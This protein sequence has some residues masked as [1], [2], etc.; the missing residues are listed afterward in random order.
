MN[1]H[2][3]SLTLRLVLGLNFLFVA[4]AH[5]KI[6]K[7]YVEEPTKITSWI[8]NSSILGNIIA[9]GLF[10]SSI[11]LLVGYKTIWTTLSAIALLL[12]NHIALLFTKPAND[13]FSGPFYNSFHHSVPFI[14]FAIVLLYALST[15]KDFS[16]DRLLK[17]K[18]NELT[19]IT[20]NEIVFPTGARLRRVPT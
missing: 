8:T 10:I 14:G 1:K 13:P 20:K 12:T 18:E 4:I 19:A 3:I 7:F 11:F 6:W 17:Q 5:L 16:I 15:N 9:V 2:I